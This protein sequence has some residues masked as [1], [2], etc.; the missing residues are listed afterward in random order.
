MSAE[1]GHVAF[2]Y[3]LTLDEARRRTAIL[4]AVGQD[5]DPVAVLAEEDRAYAMLYSGLDD[6]QQRIFDMLVAVGV[7][8]DRVSGR[9]PD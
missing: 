3:D 2:A 6:E 9:V 4:E 1:R 7:L 5:W 8:P